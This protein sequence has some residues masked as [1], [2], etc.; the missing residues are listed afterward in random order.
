MKVSEFL[1]RL[2]DEWKSG[3]NRFEQVGEILLGAKCN[4]RLIGVCGL[5]VDPY[6][7]SP[8]VGRLRHLYVSPHTRQA[9]LGRETGELDLGTRNSRVRES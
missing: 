5:N 4:E 2:S 8:G 7:R 6:V 1:R 3:A 9:G